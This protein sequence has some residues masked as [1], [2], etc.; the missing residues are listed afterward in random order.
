MNNLDQIKKIQD[1]KKRLLDQ[2]RELERQE[3]ELKESDFKVGDW[4]HHVNHDVTYQIVELNNN[5][6]KLIAR[7]SKNTDKGAYYAFALKPAN[8][9]QIIKELEKR[10]KDAGIVVG[11]KYTLKDV[12]RKDCFQSKIA[13]IKCATE[14]SFELEGFCSIDVQNFL[15]ENG[16]VIAVKGE[17]NLATRHTSVEIIKEEPLPEING[18]KGTYDGEFFTY[19]C[20]K[21]EKAIIE[22]A[23]KFGNAEYL[24]NR[25][26]ENV[27]INLN[28]GVSISWN[29]I[30]QLNKVIKEHKA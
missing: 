13:A 18:Y 4:V 2:V 17:N 30:K 11:A 7:S 14:S 24:G 22:N 25:Y 27:D 8:N 20:A 9:N 23:Y 21:I 1:D 28:S 3:T 12:N 16:W 15:K 26:V 6:D 29:E 10:A 19:G 5:S